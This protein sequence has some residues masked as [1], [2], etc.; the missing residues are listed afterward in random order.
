MSIRVWASKEYSNK[1]CCFSVVFPILDCTLRL[2]DWDYILFA[3]SH[4]PRR[5]V[6]QCIWLQHCFATNLATFFHISCLAGCRQ[7]LLLFLNFTSLPSQTH[8]QPPPREN[9]ILA[10]FI[11]RALRSLERPLMFRGNIQKLT[12]V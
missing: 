1:L 10:D 9:L 12:M 6:R 11:L 3:T 2:I 7:T 8:Q 4:W 5:R